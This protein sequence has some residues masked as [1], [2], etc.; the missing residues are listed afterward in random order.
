[1]QIFNLLLGAI[2]VEKAAKSNVWVKVMNVEMTTIVKNHTYDL[3]K[4]P[5][6]KDIVKLKWILET[7][8]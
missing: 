6:G 2:T 3:V 4:C 5:K 8:F 1:M 7:N